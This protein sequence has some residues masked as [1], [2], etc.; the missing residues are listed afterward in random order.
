MS[1]EAFGT[2]IVPFASTLTDL[3]NLPAVP[4]D[5][6]NL[7]HAVKLPLDQVAE[8]GG[9]F[10]SLA[11]V[12]G[13]VAKPAKS[14]GGEILFRVTD[15]SGM[16][17]PL[18]KLQRFKDN[19]GIFAKTSEGFARLHEVE[20]TDAA[21]A[22]A[23]IDP[24]TLFIAATLM[25]INQKLDS[26]AEM[27]EEMFEYAKLH[28][29][30]TLVAGFKVLN[31]LREN[32]RFNT[33]NDAYLSSRHAL[34][35]AIWKD[36]EQA[37]EFQRQRLEKML[38][39]LGP[40]HLGVMVEKKARKML[41]ALKE[42]QLSCYLYAY[43]TVLDTV[44][45]GNYG[46]DYLASIAQK[47]ERYS[48][49]YFDLYTKCSESV[50]ED[51]RGSLETKLIGGLASAG[52]KLGK[53]IEATPIGDVTPIDEALIG[54]GD[55]LQDVAREGR[56]ELVGILTSAKPGFMRPFIDGVDD[57]DRLHNEPMALAMGDNA[58]YVLPMSEVTVA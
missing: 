14:T 39:E 10:A 49:E 21:S 42:Y 58:V 23:A 43:S 46:H 50:H 15:A 33:T 6:L 51:A 36:A 7:D 9:A 47:M 11:S 45:V 30:A 53:M 8:L 34:V 35:A 44:L 1:D 52:R 40:L 17:I 28:D 5:I 19:S 31:E 32:Y 20:V 18:D 54:G 57:L 2:D 37:I 48:L 3:D 22:A 25:E 26:I 29:H 24:V 56:K 41:E 38:E 13:E 4:K 55:K 27:Q 16:P 12:F